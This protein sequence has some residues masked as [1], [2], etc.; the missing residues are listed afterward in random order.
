MR[1]CILRCHLR[2]PD[3]KSHKTLSSCSVTNIVSA[4]AQS[5]CPRRLLAPPGRPHL[6]CPLPLLTPLSLPKAEH[7]HSA[8]LKPLVTVCSSHVCQRDAQPWRWCAVQISTNSSRTRTARQR[9]GSDQVDGAYS[10]AWSG[11]C[12]RE[13]AAVTA[14]AAGRPPRAGSTRSPITSGGSPPADERGRRRRG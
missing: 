5:A 6:T 9:W 7:P 12:A 8:Q 4:P 14:P 11:R 10:A 13:R 1:S 2:V 3:R